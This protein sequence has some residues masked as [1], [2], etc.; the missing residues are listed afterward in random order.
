MNVTPSFSPYN[1]LRL[2]TDIL[3]LSVRLHDALAKG[4][5]SPAAFEAA[6]N[7]TSPRLPG[8]F[9]LHPPKYNREA[10]QT[11]SFNAMIASTAMVF[12]QADTALSALSISN[13]SDGELVE[14]RELVYMIRCALAH[15]PMHAKWI[16]KSKYQKVYE[17]RSIGLRVDC[18]S[19][20]GQP[21]DP[22]QL[23]D[24]TGIFKLIEHV[25]IAVAKLDP[26]GAQMAGPE[27]VA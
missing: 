11:I 5:L 21:F 4:R 14:L 22:I 19:L 13:P 3:G 2:A 24:W 9:L 7:V 10:L 23:G 6:I 27:H 18:H 16:V 25:R 8:E 1:Q 20:N 15:D 26:V 12:I 17:L